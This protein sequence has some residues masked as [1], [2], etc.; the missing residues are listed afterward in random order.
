MPDLALPTLADALLIFALLATA[1]HVTTALI[2]ALRCRRPCPDPLPEQS[3]P[4]IT[5]LRPVCGLD[6]HDALT[7]GSTFELDYPRY[8]IVFCAAHAHDP[9]A[10]LVRQLIARYPGTRARLLTGDDRIS[11]NPKL[12]NL[13][14]AWRAPTAAWVVMADSNV[15]MPPDYLQRLLAAWRPGTGLVCSPPVGTLPDTFMAEVEAAFLNTYQARWQLAAD[16]AGF[17]FA[18]GKSMLWRRDML[19]AAGGIEALGRELAEDAAATKIVRDGGRRV[20]LT[21][22]PFAQPLGAR[23]ARQVWDRQLRWARLRR[24]TFPA[25]FAPEL[26][27]GALPPLVAIVAWS[28]L[29]GPADLP[30]YAPAFTLAAIWYATEALLAHAAGWHLTRRSPAAWILRDALLPLLWFSAV[31]GSAL[32]WRGTDLTPAKSV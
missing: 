21:A 9:G 12:N 5:I 26:L 15:L 18:Q 2:A 19:D 28:H 16:S 29:A 20:R 30:V 3:L 8:D 1:L 25:A 4:A 23:T 31:A 17:G 22:A 7:L 32:T 6:Q 10:R 14:K 13:V 27:S 24:M 11:P